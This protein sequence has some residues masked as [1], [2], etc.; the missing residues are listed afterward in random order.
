[1]HIARPGR[2]LFRGRDRAD[3]GGR[4]SGAGSSLTVTV[5]SPP[6]GHPTKT[7][8]EFT[9]NTYKY[10][11]QGFYGYRGGIS[12]CAGSDGRTVV[13]WEDRGQDGGCCNDGI[14]AQRYD[15]DGATLGGEFRANEFTATGEVFRVQS[16]R[17]RR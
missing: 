10:G 14:Y 13:A 1:M 16:G 7:G 9:V 2:S 6:L 3:R 17:S 12:T 15:A 11:T 5:Q 4:D 8:P